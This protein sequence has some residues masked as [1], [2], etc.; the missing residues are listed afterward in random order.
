MKISLFSV[1]KFFLFAALFSVVIVTS[2][3]LF[4]FIVGKYVWF[5]VTV[6]LSFVFFLLGILFQDF[7]VPEIAGTHGL[8]SKRL[9]AILK[10]PLVIAVTFFVALYLLAGFFGYDPKASFWSNFERGEGGFQLLNFYIFFLMLRTLFTTQKDWKN[11]F[12]VSLVVSGLVILYGVAASLGMKGFIG[13]SGFCGRV[14]GSLGNPA[15]FAP[16]L[17]FTGFFALWL[18]FSKR[19]GKNTARN[20][21]YA[22]LIFVLFFFF[23]LS[24]TRGTF[25]GLGVGVIAAFGYLFLKLEKSKLKTVS[26]FVALVLMLLGVLGFML[27]HNNIPIVPFCSSSSRLLEIST[28]DETAQTRFWTWGSAIK[29]WEERPLLGWGPEN[30]SVVF[31]KYF[32]PRHFVPGR[33]SETWFDRAHSVYF[34]YLTETGILGLLSY[35]GIFGVY[36]WEFFKKTKE[37]SPIINVLFFAIPIAYLTQGIALFDVLPIYLVLFTTLAFASFYFNLQEEK[38]HIL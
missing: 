31:D 7:K 14:S 13:P 28:K 2:S 35:L 38:T 27:R 23:L 25:L 30:F 6:E 26:G 1:S 8:V 24:Q 32:D 9:R 12:G 16:Y 15:Y 19:E 10:E 11:F 17:M 21:G 37:R 3:T 33:P 22:F 20:I 34:D 5:R 4:P 18:W 29:G 36:F